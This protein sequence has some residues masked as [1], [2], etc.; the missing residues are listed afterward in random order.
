MGGTQA[1]GR[2]DPDAAR[3]GWSPRLANWE[4]AAVP[5]DRM[6]D[7][8]RDFEKLL[9]NAGY[10]GIMFGHWGQGC[11]HC[12]IDWDLRS[13]DGVQRFRQFMEQAADLVVSYGG[14]L[15]GEHGDGHGRAELWPKMFSP[16]LMRAFA[17]F[18]RVWDPDNKMNPH[19]LIDPYPLDT[20]LREGTEYRPI[21]LKTVFRYRGD[22][23]DPEHPE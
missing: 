1:R 4:D 14:S 16:E 12:R 19:K 17:D 7:Y 10:D 20:H 18:K 5:P 13:R 15:S 6:G 3:V 23:G 11:I 2:V 8:L 9:D 22:D 21:H